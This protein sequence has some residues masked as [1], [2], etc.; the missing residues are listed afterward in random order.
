MLI[1]D[2]QAGFS[3]AA[4]PVVSVAAYALLAQKIGFVRAERL[5]EG[6][7]VLLAGQM[8]DLLLLKETT[9]AGSGLAGLEQFL[10]KASRRHNS[11]A[12]MYRAQ[13]IATPMAPEIFGEMLRN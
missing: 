4:D 9:P 12:A 2:E 7:Q 10:V 5:M 8:R 3:F 11:A 1:C 6:E 13:R